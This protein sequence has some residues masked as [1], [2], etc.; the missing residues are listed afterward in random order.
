M[1]SQNT[2]FKPSLIKTMGICVAGVLIGMAGAPYFQ[3]AYSP[4][5]MVNGTI[6]YDSYKKINNSDGQIVKD[7][8]TAI[9]QRKDGTRNTITCD[10]S[11]SAGAMDRFMGEGYHVTLRVKEQKDGTSPACLEDFVVVL[12]PRT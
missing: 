12:A 7:V 4:R 6:V 9:I 5:N 8:Y 11:E 2:I 10:E 1:T 3:N